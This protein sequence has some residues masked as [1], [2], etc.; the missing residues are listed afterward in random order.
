MATLLQWPPRR[1]S[2]ISTMAT[3]PQQQF[4]CNGHLP[5]T[6][7]SLQRPPFYNG[8]LAVTATSPQWP[9]IHNSR[10][11]AT[12][13]SP[14]RPPLYNGHLF[15]T[16]TFF[17]DSPYIDSC[18]NLFTMA[19]FFVPKVAAVERFSCKTQFKAKQFLDPLRTL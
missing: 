6:A 1:N 8:H 12:A 7:T 5:T 2:H 4:L 9:P 17:A 15:T 13:T 19:S 14:Q 10:F 16:A 3:Y 18:L 11:S